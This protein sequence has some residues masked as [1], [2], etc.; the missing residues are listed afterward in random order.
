MDS[1]NFFQEGSCFNCGDSPVIFR[2]HSG[3]YLCLNCFKNSIEAI[4]RKTISVYKLLS[5]N[6]KILV[7]F[8]GG[9]SSTTLLYNIKKIQQSVYHGKPISALTI[10]TS[11]D[12]ENLQR[13]KDFCEK[14]SL[15][16]IFITSEEFSSD[17][18]SDI[19]KNMRNTKYDIIRIMLN[20]MN[21]LDYNVLCVGFNLTDIAEICLTQLLKESEKFE[22]NKQSNIKVI[23]PL[24]RIPELEI[25]MYSKLQNFN[26]EIHSDTLSNIDNVVHKFLDYCSKKSPEIE[27][28]L[29]K[30]YLEL[31]GIGFFDHVMPELL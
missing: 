14:Y 18:K 12:Q 2:R 10:K 6:D 27:F 1:V 19:N 15:E 4:I 20:Y 28:N 13:T 23:F 30:V 8:S 11:M 7:A 17:I 26:I 24:M 3:Q 22:I 21:T 25:L 5:P 29:F 16:Q 31:S 9:I